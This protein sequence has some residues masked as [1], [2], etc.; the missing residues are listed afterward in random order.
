MSDSV[1][2][3]AIVGG[4]VAL[5]LLVIA[6]INWFR[7]RPDPM[8]LV[9][10]REPMFGKDFHEKYYPDLPRSVVFQVREEFSRV[11]G[12]PA[13]FIRPEDTLARLGP[14]GGEE[15]MEESIALLFPYLEN[16][17]NNL[18]RPLEGTLDGY[19]RA[20]A[21]MYAAQQRYSLQSVLPDNEHPTG[22]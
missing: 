4:T 2:I 13:D 10:E 7:K 19:V 6:G 21:A 16:L 22:A 20:A 1:F 8:Q 18:A 15:A 5:S 11:I 14:S 17:W 9:L 3:V 12:I